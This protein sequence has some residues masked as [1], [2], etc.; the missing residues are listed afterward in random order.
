MALLAPILHLPLY[1]S[2]SS[3]DF[4]VPLIKR[5]FSLSLALG[6]AIWLALAKR[7]WEVVTMSLF[8][9][10]VLRG[11]SVST[12]CTSAITAENM[13]QRDHY[14][15]ISLYVSIHLV[16]RG[17]T[18]DILCRSHGRRQDPYL[19]VI[20]NIKMATTEH[21]TKCGLLL[22]SGPSAISQAT[23]QG[24][25]LGRGSDSFCLRPGW[26]NGGLQLKSHPSLVLLWL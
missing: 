17:R 21:S 25:S 2:P 24:A 16:S 11:L 26:G 3:C 7:R 6:L 10:Y 20:N 5:T 8:Q 9:A 19:K 4:R 13:H 15:G 18:G 14:Q 22:Y 12:S 1:P 23:S